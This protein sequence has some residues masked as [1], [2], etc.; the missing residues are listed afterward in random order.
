MYKGFLSISRNSNNI[1]KVNNTQ[2]L[3]DISYVRHIRIG[4]PRVCRRGINGCF[5][6]SGVWP[7]NW[8]MPTTLSVATGI[9]GTTN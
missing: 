6:C 1:V 4:T 5:L 7:P 9:P 3:R 2:D 8:C